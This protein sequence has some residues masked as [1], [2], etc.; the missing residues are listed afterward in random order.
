MKRFFKRSSKIMKL[1]ILTMEFINYKPRSKNTLKAYSKDLLKLDKWFDGWD[2]EKIKPK[3]LVQLLEDCKIGASSKLRL[4]RTFSSF[5]H[6]ASEVHGISNIIKFIP[7]P[8]V[9]EQEFSALTQTE[10]E[11]YIKISRKDTPRDS[12]LCLLPLFTGLR[13]SELKSLNLDQVSDGYVLNVEGKSKRLRSVPYP[14]L[15]SKDAARFFKWRQL[16]DL[17]NKSPLFLSKIGRM[18][19]KT[20]YRIIH[21]NLILAGVAKD[22]AHPHALRHTYAMLMLDHIGKSEQNPAKALVSVSRLLGHEFISTTMKYQ[23]PSKEEL[24]KSIQEIEIG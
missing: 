17:D 7:K 10:I 6:Y 20:I 13:V 8:R 2:I 21:K 9:H 18:N 4:I 1:N 23:K 22:R 12:F 24:K 19:E 3:N 14:N 15:L 5:W 11:N 16:L